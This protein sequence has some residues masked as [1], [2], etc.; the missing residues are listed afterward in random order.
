ME[1]VGMIA[2]LH[3]LPPH[4]SANR[5]RIETF[6]IFSSAPPTGTMYPRPGVTTSLSSVQLGE[7]LLS[8]AKHTRTPVLVRESG[9]PWG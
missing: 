2:I 4:I 1:A 3:L 6:P 7:Y 5:R 8:A 9:A